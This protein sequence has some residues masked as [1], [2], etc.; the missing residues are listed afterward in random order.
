MSGSV[1]SVGDRLGLGVS[2]VGEGSGVSW[3]CAPVKVHPTATAT[4]VSA[5]TN[6]PAARLGFFAMR[7]IRSRSPLAPEDMVVAVRSSS[8]GLEPVVTRDSRV[9]P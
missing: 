8:V 2:P 6:T 4:T 7:A 9:R 5:I 3:D 1:P